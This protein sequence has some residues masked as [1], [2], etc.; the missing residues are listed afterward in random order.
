MG[1][2][3]YIVT[4]HRGGGQFGRVQNSW[5]FVKLTINDDSIWMGTMLQEVLIKREFIQTIVHQRC[6]IN[7]RFI[8]KHNDPMIKEVIEFWTFSPKPVAEVLKS[9]GYP[10]SEDG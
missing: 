4:S 6:F 2:W 5:P 3:G 8:F 9:Q 10:L 1:E 7:H